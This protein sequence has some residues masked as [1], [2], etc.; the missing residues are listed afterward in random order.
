MTWITYRIVAQSGTTFTHFS[1]FSNLKEAQEEWELK[2]GQKAKSIALD[3]DKDELDFS[4][5]FD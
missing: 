2:F 1:R 5:L 3:D 4:D